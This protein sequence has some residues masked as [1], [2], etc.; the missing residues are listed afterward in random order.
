[1]FRTSLNEIFEATLMISL[2][3]LFTIAGIGALQQ[4]VD[5]SASVAST[6]APMPIAHAN[7]TSRQA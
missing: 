3:G 7:V 6:N 4:P 1:M 5:Q 2:V